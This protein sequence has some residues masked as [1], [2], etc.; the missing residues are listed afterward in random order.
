VLLVGVAM[1]L[2]FLTNL[3]RS[4]FL[5]G[6]AYAYGSDA[7]EGRLH[8]ATGFAVLGLTCAGLLGL[9]PLFNAA[10]WRRWLGVEPKGSAGDAG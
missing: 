8:D 6:W 7:I 2:A 9:L 5:T 1:L 3:L 4:L 10:N